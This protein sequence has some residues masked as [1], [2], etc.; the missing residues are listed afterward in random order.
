MLSAKQALGYL[1]GA[2]ICLQGCSGSGND[3]LK[4]GAP[5]FNLPSLSQSEKVRLSDFQGQKAVM[6]AFWASWCPPCVEE[7]PILNRIQK[8]Y[9]NE[10]ELLAIN[11]GEE[12]GQIEKFS[13]EYPM[14]YQILLDNDE[15]VAG[16]YEISGLP[17]IVILAKSGEIIY[18]GFNIPDLKA[19]LTE[20]NI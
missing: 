5:D 19:L 9:K 18:Y 13:K 10:L 17:V 4:S 14:N 20:K 7:I 15:K 2:L 11:V 8:D 12:R 3:M 6:L 1:V 16:D